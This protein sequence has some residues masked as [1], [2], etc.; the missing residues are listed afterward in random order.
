[1]TK[2]EISQSGILRLS[3]SLVAIVLPALLF[4]RGIYGSFLFTFPIPLLWQI[5]FLGRPFGSLGLRATALKSSVIAGIVSGRFLGFLG[6]NVLKFLGITG[7]LLSNAHIVRFD[8]GPLHAAFSLPNELGY[9]LLAISNTPVGLCLYLMFSIFI[10]GL[11]EELFWR[12]FLQQKAANYIAL[13]AAIWLTAVLFALS[14]FYIFVILP[15]MPGVA[16]LISIALSGAAWGYL[17]KYFR[18]LWAAALS[19]GITAFIIWKYYFF[20]LQ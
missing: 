1:M 2:T 11:G 20:S 18:N 3:I 7:R 16:F 4:L 8:V 6:G 14:H 10:I 17:C 12:G 5:G 13:D 9:R 19:H 15:L